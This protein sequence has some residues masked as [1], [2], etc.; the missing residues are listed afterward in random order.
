MPRLS[1]AKQ[2]AADLAGELAGLTGVAATGTGLPPD[3]RAR[4][5]ESVFVKAFT[6]FEW[7]LEELFF[8][9]LTGETRVDGA[10]PKMRVRDAD[11]ARVV[12]GG[13][14]GRYLTWL[15]LEETTTRSERLLVGGEPFVRLGV[16]DQ[17]KAELRRAQLVRN[18]TAHKSV[19]A[20]RKFQ[21][22]TSN[23]FATA[24]DFLASKSGGQTACEAILDNLTRYGRALVV[25]PT[26]A[27]KLLG[28]RDPFRTGVSP[29][30][31]SYRCEKCSSVYTLT[32]TESLR[33]PVCDPS[34][35]HCGRRPKTATFRAL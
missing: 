1:K 18:A 10:A 24:G 11:L 6:E 17:V 3:V 33:C 34:C 15:P 35:A 30:V 4:L 25:T 26:D 8:A 28:P 5:L 23:A 12:A 19:E 27:E 14:G 32:A 13:G 2:L 16:R 31:G 29:G 21:S 22:V 20:Q 7:F 9:I